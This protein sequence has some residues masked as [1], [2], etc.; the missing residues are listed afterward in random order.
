MYYNASDSIRNTIIRRRH[1]NPPQSRTPIRPYLEQSTQQESNAPNESNA[2]EELQTNDPNEQHYESDWRNFFNIVRNQREELT[3]SQI[4]ININED[5]GDDF[6]TGES[7]SVSDYL[8]EETNNVVF[9]FK[10]KVSFLSN[11]T[12]ITNAINDKSAI[13]YG[14]IRVDTS[15][16]PRR[17]NLRLNE[18]YFTLRSIGGY[19]LVSMTKIQEIINNPN[20]RCVEISSEPINNLVTTASFYVTFI[21]HN[22]LD[23][24]GASHCQEGQEEQ[25]YDLFNIPINSGGKRRTNLR[26]YKRRKHKQI[27]HKRQSKRRRTNKRKTHKFRK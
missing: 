4:K 15:F 14:C 20:I 19:G 6:I 8:N 27:T 10:N 22:R 7:I 18:P 26:T 5:K 2:P 13:K 23:V 16:K 9:Y 3:N 1:N 12:L 21:E 17:T 11:K 24:T 25:V